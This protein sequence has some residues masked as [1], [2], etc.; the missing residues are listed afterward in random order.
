M[1]ITFLFF[2]EKWLVI[3]KRLLVRHFSNRDD[4]WV[5]KKSYGLHS[6]CS[7]NKEWLVQEGTALGKDIIKSVYG[8]VWIYPPAAQA[9]SDGKL[10]DSSEG[11]GVLS[12]TRGG[13][14]LCYLTYWSA[15]LVDYSSSSDSNPSKDSLFVAPSSEFL[16]APV[17]APPGFHRWPTI[18]V[19]PDEAIPFGRPYHIHPNG[20]HFT[21]DS[22]S[23]NS[24]SDSSSDISLGSS[25]DSLSD[26]EFIYQA[27]MHWRSAP[28]ATLYPPTT[29]ES[30]LDSSSERS[31]DSSST[32][33][34]LSRK[35]NM[36]SPTT[37]GYHH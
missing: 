8:C 20:P 6:P 16:L 12:C 2:D 1:V 37:F 25:S 36:R 11:C 27:Y 5:A 7:C 22:F 34:G 32:F 17:V 9:E 4:V 33:A 35:R 28:L 21:S 29:S 23:S 19:R 13:S 14:S 3:A 31:L 24:S 30:S 15:R 10:E 18:L 26:S